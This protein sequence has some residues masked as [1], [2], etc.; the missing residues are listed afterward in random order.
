MAEPEVSSLVLFTAHLEQTAAFYG[1]IGLDLDREDH[2]EGPVH[3]AVELGSVH[4]AIY[5][6]ESAGSAPDRRA[7]GSSFPGFYVDSLDATQDALAGLGSPVLKSHEEMPWG[8]RI[9]VA[10]PDGRP[11]EVN[12][13]GHC[14]PAPQS[15]TLQR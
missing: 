1:A 12:Q 5:P 3:H 8:C 10:D 7:A 11:V 15:A 4:F 13:R 9:V 6:A 14:N 2:G